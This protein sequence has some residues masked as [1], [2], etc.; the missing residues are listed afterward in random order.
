MMIDPRVALLVAGCGLLGAVIFAEVAPGTGTA[1]PSIAARP[2]SNTPAIFPRLPPPPA[3]DTVAAN[4]DRPVF[5]PTR[6]PAEVAQNGAAGPELTDKRLAGIVIEP[7]RRFAIFA[8][9]GAKPLTVTEGDDVSGWRI[10]TITA[11]EVSVRGPAGVKTL[12]P[13]MDKNAPAPVRTPL[14]AA[15]ERPPARS[16]P[17]SP[18]TAQQHPNTV[19]PRAN[20]GYRPGRE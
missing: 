7:D 18:A 13:E 20:A 2:R 16:F 5:S 12:Q 9:A 14:A 11:R 17:P 15:S 6:R 10:E 3:A 4:L 8:I 1:L 19:A